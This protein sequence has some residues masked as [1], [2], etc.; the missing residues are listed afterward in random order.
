MFFGGD[1]FDHFGHGGGGR[2]NR[3]SRGGGGGAAVDTTKLYDTLGVSDK[4]RCL[5]LRCIFQHSHL[6]SFAVP[7]YG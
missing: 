4:V 5:F 6:R 7:F 2:S 1:P 3:G